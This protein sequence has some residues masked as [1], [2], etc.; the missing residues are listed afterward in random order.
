M[1]YQNLLIPCLCS[2]DQLLVWVVL[3]SG[4]AGT[5]H[6]SVAFFLHTE[7]RP[8]AAK[9]HAPPHV[10]AIN[11][12]KQLPAG[13]LPRMWANLGGWNWNMLVQPLNWHLNKYGGWRIIGIQHK[14]LKFTLKRTWFGVCFP[15]LF[16]F[17]LFS[18]WWSIQTSKEK[19]A[20][21]FAACC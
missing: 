18:F 9:D 20:T 19:T 7:T 11:F 5:A 14:A 12:A 15:I 10:A 3:C 17:P 2:S 1:I 8:P 21:V 6:C 13:N 4:T 16:R